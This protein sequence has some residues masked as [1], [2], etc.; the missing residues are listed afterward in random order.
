MAR[1]ILTELVSL[2]DERLYIP[3]SRR[4]SMEDFRTD[5]AGERLQPR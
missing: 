1:R 4:R 3:D 5:P 2:G